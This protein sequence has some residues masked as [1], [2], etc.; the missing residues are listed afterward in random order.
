MLSN[1]STE[2]LQKELELRTGAAATRPSLLET[3]NLAPLIKLCE[4]YLD[5][6]VKEG[7]AKDIKHWV[8]EATLTTLYG[9]EVWDWLNEHKRW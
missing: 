1:F 6:V 4:N 9:K 7:G 3:F 2:E 8:Y 5:T